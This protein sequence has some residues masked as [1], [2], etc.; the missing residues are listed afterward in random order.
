MISDPS[1]EGTRVLIWDQGVLIQVALLLRF[2]APCYR[3]FRNVEHG[4]EKP[5]PEL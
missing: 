5:L 4:N 2:Y 3:G 1:L